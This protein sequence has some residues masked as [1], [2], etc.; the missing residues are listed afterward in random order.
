MLASRPS[1][2]DPPSPLPLLRFFFGK[3]TDFC[4]WVSLPATEWV[5]GKQTEEVLSIK[6]TEQGGEHFH[7]IAQ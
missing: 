1:V 5:K 7:I 3:C 4:F 6:N 2:V